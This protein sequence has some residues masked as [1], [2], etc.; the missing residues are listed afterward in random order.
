MKRF[1]TVAVLLC[2][3]VG[4]S[5]CLRQKYTHGLPRNNFNKPAGHKKFVKQHAPKEEKSMFLVKAK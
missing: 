1:T 4:M 2:L 3:A 5:S